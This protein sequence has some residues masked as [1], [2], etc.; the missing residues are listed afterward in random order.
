MLHLINS[1]AECS[2]LY[3]MLNGACKANCPVG[4]YEDMEEGRCGQCHPTCGSC[5]GPLTD[6][7]ETCSTFSPKLYKGT[8]SKNCPVGTYYETGA[9]DCQGESSCGILLLFTGM[10][11]LCGKV[12]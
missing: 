7:C 8:C 3:L 2:F 12:C 11:S 4:Y 1:P 6:D 10:Y 9:M 5:S